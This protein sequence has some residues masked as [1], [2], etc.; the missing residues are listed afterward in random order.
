MKEYIDMKFN[1]LSK[2]Y[3]NSTRFI[4]SNPDCESFSS[5]M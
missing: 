1:G 5:I 3:D 4:C 2:R